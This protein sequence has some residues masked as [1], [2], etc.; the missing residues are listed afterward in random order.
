MNDLPEPNKPG[1]PAS[2]MSDVRA[3]R[4]VDVAIAMGRSITVICRLNTMPPAS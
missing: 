3:A 1:R 2:S 4:R